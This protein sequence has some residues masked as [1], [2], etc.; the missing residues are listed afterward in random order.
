MHLRSA[1]SLWHTDAC[2]CG[3]VR[4]ELENASSQI[5]L[6]WFLW[7]LNTMM[8]GDNRGVQEFGVKGHPG[9]MWGH[10]LNKFKMLCLHNSIDFD[11]IWVKRSLARGSFGCRNFWSEVILGLFV[12]TVERSNFK[13]P[14]TTKLT[15]SMCWSRLTIKKCSWWPL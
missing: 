13:Q 9:V 11:E 5:W 4:L 12:V 1:M 8:V 15:M 7:Y 3:F 2:I 14:I 10:C 6:D